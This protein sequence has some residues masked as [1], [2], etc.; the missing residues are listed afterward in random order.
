M[1]INVL[2][3]RGGARRGTQEALPEPLPIGDDSDI[4]NCPACARPLAVGARR[5]PGCGT[6]LLLGVQV[7]RAVVFVA[8]GIAGGLLVASAFVLV[9]LNLGLA[10]VRP[11]ALAPAQPVASAIAEPAPVASVAPL[12]SAAPVVP[13][14]PPASVSALAR[15]AEM[16]VRIA[17]G[18]PVL[19]AALAEA[20]VD[21]GV[22][23]EV[24]RSMTAD[25]AYA[26]GAA[27][28]LGRWD[29]AAYVSAGLSALYADIRATARDGL[30]K[31]LGSE[32]A[33][34]AAAE[35]ML[36]VLAG[37][38]PLDAASRDLAGVAGIELPVVPLPDLAPPADAPDGAPDDAASEASAP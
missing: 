33:Y 5:C 34:R 11:E 38:A 29:D 20:T 15:T 27:D 37:L 3:G 21:T 16:N 10:A 12:P 36:V 31:S 18:I 22:V 19:Q 8:G 24:L 30:A 4:F 23:A 35:R 25:A 13:A 17:A 14:I 26:A 28:R 32:P 7:R 1:T 9:S 6:R 2:R